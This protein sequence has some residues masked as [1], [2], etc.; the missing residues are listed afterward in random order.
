[1]KVGQLAATV[2]T[3]G[4]DDKCSGQDSAREGHEELALLQRAL[5]TS[6]VES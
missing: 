5:S 2:V 3:V 1:M 6:L 4:V